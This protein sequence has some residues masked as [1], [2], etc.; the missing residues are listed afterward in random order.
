VTISL[1]AHAGRA[2]KQRAGFPYIDKEV[3]V[4]RLSVA[5]CMKKCTRNTRLSGRAPDGDM[6][7]DDRLMTDEVKRWEV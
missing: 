5:R 1:Q 2:G 3:A 4:K 7:I 6:E